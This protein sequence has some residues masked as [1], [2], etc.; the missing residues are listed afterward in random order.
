MNVTA[1]RPIA[2][3][4]TRREIG[5]ATAVVVV[6]G[7]AAWFAVSAARSPGHVLAEFIAGFIV[8]AG[9]GLVAA[10]S[11]RDPTALLSLML[12]FLFLVPE[13]YTLAGPL[14]AAGNPAI[15]TGMGILGL[16]VAGRLLGWIRP[17]PLHPY[18]WALWAF[19]LAACMSFAAGM[20]RN[21][22][23]TESSSATRTIFSTTAMIGVGIMATD[24][25]DTREKI[26]KV[27]RLLVY[28]TTAQAAIGILEFFT[29]L[30]YYSIANIPGL[31]LNTDLTDATR[32][33][34]VRIQAASAHSIEFSVAIAAAAP[35]ALHF[36]MTNPTQR[37]RRI[38]RACL[39][40]MLAA[41]PLSMSRSG[42]LGIVVGLGFYMVAMT[43]RGRANLLVFGI[44]GSALLEG[45]VPGVVNTL[46]YYIFAG[47]KDPSIQGRTEDYAHL[48][49]LMLDHWTFGRGFGTFSPIVYFF[50]D[51]QLL[52]TLLTEGVVGVA[53]L[54]TVFLVGMGVARGA[55]KR[56]L[57][58][59]DAG[60]G[61]A[62]AGG[63]AAL[64]A[65]AATFDEFSFYQCA[66]ET[67]LLGGCAAAL[68]TIARREQRATDLGAP[69]LALMSNM[70][71]HAVVIDGE[72]Q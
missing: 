49:G 22:N 70:P 43:W 27:L 24:A 16:W 17:E 47:S 28:L 7:V 59:N 8:L 31:V 45:A 52:L 40:V 18:R 50:L 30:D 64:L 3:R 66:L 71:R 61:Q 63:L 15:L 51:N 19:T 48:P 13:K 36:G 56:R 57:R 26:H 14:K 21:L 33:G 60:L 12:C 69:E 44:L 37:G 9:I 72:L 68:W 53:A 23:P 55:R 62:L 35:L 32:G 39:V 2:R 20:V 25:L 42:L 38:N 6:F 54:F 5:V 29:S 4:P 58:E 46:R 65:A 41:V 11:R 1:L 67:F 34:L 10:L